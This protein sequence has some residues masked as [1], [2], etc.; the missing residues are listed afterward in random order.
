MYPLFTS[1]TWQDYLRAADREQ[2][3]LEAVRRYR[4]S[5]FFREGLDAN[6]YFRGENPTVARKTVL[7]VKKLRRRDASGRLRSD[8]A[9]TDVVGNRIGSGFL[10]RLVTQQNQ[11]L[12]GNGC[13]LKDE[14]TKRLLGHDFDRVLAELGERA[15]LH[16]VAWLYWNCDH[17]EL[18]EACADPLSGFVALSDEL[19]GEPMLGIQFWQ[20]EARR[21]LHI[22]LFEPDGVTL[23]RK[24]GDTLVPLREK[25]PYVLRRLTDLNGDRTEAAEPWPRLPIIPLWANGEHCS[26]LTPAIRAKI[27]AYD[28]ILSDL[29]DNLDRANDVYWVL[30]NFGGTA[31][32]VAETLE[33]ISRLKAVACVPDGSGQ[34]A[35]AEPRTIEVPYQARQAAL[36]LLRRNIYE[37]YM[38]MDP[39]RLTGTQLTNV[40]IRTASAAM[41]LKADRYEWQ[42]F[43]CVRSLL[44]LLGVDTEE[45][46]FRRRTLGNESETVADIAAM[47]EDIDRATALKLNPYLQPEEVDALLRNA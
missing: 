34:S 35:T 4:A 36:E 29:A 44:G 28:R 45:I 16:G 33:Q 31:E 40:A 9:L 19:T 26:E 5:A 3:V 8:S 43:R 11:Y 41:D 25:R 6:A 2:C 10:H 38:A 27:D 18:L 24:E 37:D 17:A 42:V 13:T 32:D 23:L 21:P 47:R 30:N 39:D 12:L 20:L 15:L 14:G 46:R 22:R 1:I 7:R